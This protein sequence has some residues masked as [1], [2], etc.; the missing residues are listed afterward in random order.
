MRNATNANTTK[1]SED[2]AARRN[3][4]SESTTPNIP[5]SAFICH[6]HIRG[7][8]L[9]GSWQ[10]GRLSAGGGGPLTQEVLGLGNLGV[11][12][13]K[14]FGGQEFFD[15][16]PPGVAILGN[17]FGKFFFRNIGILL[18]VFLQLFVFFR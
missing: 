16:L 1:C 8:S 3:E 13:F 15:F 7:C 17:V 12:Y 11:P 6:C 14:L 2:A 4:L 10:N 9:N 5:C 18:P